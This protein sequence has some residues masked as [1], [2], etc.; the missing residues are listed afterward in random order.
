M[1]GLSIKK[2]DLPATPL[3]GE[4]SGGCRVHGSSSMLPA[5][6]RMP[7]NCRPAV[8]NR[9]LVEGPSALRLIVRVLRQLPR[10]QNAAVFFSTWVLLP[11]VLGTVGERILSSTGSAAGGG[12][13]ARDVGGAVGAPSCLDAQVD[14]EHVLDVRTAWDM[15]VNL[16]YVIQH[17]ILQLIGVRVL[18]NDPAHSVVSEHSR[19]ATTNRMPALPVLPLPPAGL[20]ANRSG[21]LSGRSRSQPSGER[22]FPP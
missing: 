6:C 3:G 16:H 9:W 13:T 15:A 14:T 7:R 11:I 4:H 5:P 19:I 21:F 20:A 10:W 18:C 8:A 17:V 22:M 2:M 12:S 1:N